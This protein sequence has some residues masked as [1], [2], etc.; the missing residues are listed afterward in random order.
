[1][2]GRWSTRREATSEREAMKKLVG[3]LAFLALLLSGTVLAPMAN[4]GQR[5][6]REC[7]TRGEYR[8]VSRGM[9]VLRVK[10]IFDQRGVE[11]YRGGG[12]M[13]KE[14]FT[15]TDGSV[16]VVYKHSR[17]RRTWVMQYKYADF[18]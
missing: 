13:E 14:Y 10:D 12:W 11:V 1:M 9:S 7:V 8:E 5:D 15:C 3:V 16:N 17:T 18:Y 4:A 2:V 6:T